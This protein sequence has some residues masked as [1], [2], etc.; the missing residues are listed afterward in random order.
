LTTLDELDGMAVFLAVADVG[1]HIERG[2]LVP[3][4][5]AYSTGDRH[6]LRSARSSTIFGA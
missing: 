3:V 1:A 2:E 4:L 5:E 6:R